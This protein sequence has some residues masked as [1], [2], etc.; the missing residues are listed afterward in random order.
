MGAIQW[1]L[2]IQ[3]KQALHYAAA[4][5]VRHA[6]REHGY[7]QAVNEGLARGF[8]PFWL[9]TPP[10]ADDHLARGIA[11]GW[12]AWEREHPDASVFTDHGEMARTVTGDPIPAALEVPN[13][14]LRYRD[15]TAGAVSGK[16]VQQANRYQ[17]VMTYGVE[18]SVPVINALTVRVMEMIDG[19]RATDWLQLVVN[20]LGQA[21]RQTTRQWTCG[22]YRMPELPGGSAVWRLPVRVRAEGWM[23]SALRSD[24]AINSASQDGQA[25]VALANR[26]AAAVT[27]PDVFSGPPRSADNGTHGAS[28]NS[29]AGSV[30]DLLRDRLGQDGSGSPSGGGSSNGRA[31]PGIDPVRHPG[32]CAP[33]VG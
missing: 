29:A 25:A 15:S 30:A 23:Q 7:G 8:A 27:G 1:A 20:H 19:C 5:G 14:S 28:H 18:L 31:R 4:Q 33:S 13:D 16:S 10:V 21:D 24:A 12:V 2:V 32:Q 22:F 11:T 6:V 26:P 9:L 3:A 17:L